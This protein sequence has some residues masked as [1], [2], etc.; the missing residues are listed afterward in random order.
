MVKRSADPSRLSVQMG[1]D[2]RINSDVVLFR[3]AT[4]NLID[5][6]LKYGKKS[7]MVHVTI[8]QKEALLSITI[9]NLPGNTGW[10]DSE[11]LFQ[12]YY[13]SPMAQKISGTGLGLY[14]THQ[15]S[16][17]LGGSLRYTP[18]ATHIGFTLCL[19]L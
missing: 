13:R 15:L 12:K 19:P 5:N 9:K 1:A 2:V 16:L 6:A 3:L 7:A 11:Q 17:I 18:S 14:L 4:A 8:E 10:P